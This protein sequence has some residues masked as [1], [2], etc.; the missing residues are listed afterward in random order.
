MN[1]HTYTRFCFFFCRH[2]FVCLCSLS[3]VFCEAYF[4][5]PVVVLLTQRNAFLLC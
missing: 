5:P 4:T 2:F 1:T 3:L